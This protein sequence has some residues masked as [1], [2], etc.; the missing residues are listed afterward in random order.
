MKRPKG[1]MGKEIFEKSVALVEKEGPA[2]GGYVGLHHFG[3]SLLHPQLEEYLQYLKVK[4]VDWILSTNGRLLNNKEIREMLLKY[5]GQLVI[6]LEN[7][8][9]LEDLNRLILERE[10]QRSK[11]RIMLQTFGTTDLSNLVAG[12]YQL[13]KIDQHSWAENGTGNHRKCSFLNLNW[14]CILWDGTISS[15]CMDM[16]GE[17]NLG[18]VNGK[19]LFNRPWR[20]CNT[21][22]V[23]HST[24]WSR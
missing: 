23:V 21:C 17:I 13:I 3:E 1:F 11:L 10:A 19:R 20:A 18:H 9:R 5:D 14:V 15:C 8:G 22:E 6:S 24:S 4:K 16:E 12:D 2:R 7:G